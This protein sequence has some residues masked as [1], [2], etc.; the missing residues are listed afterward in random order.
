MNYIRQIVVRSVLLIIVP[1]NV[2]GMALE[3]WTRVALTT[4]TAWGFQRY[5]YPPF[6][7]PE[8]RTAFDL[9]LSALCGRFQSDDDAE[10][11]PFP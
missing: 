4:T 9:W 11:T 6:T 7:P 3:Y 1:F 5:D 8:W 2:I 10:E